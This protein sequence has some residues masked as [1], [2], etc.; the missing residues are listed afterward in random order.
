MRASS[1]RGSRSQ[2]PADLARQVQIPHRNSIGV[3][4]DEAHGDLD[5]PRPAAG[6]G[7]EQ[8]PRLGG[9]AAE[10]RVE[11]SG[12]SGRGTQRARRA[13]RRSRRAGDHRLRAAASRRP[14]AGAASPGGPGAGDD[15]AE[16]RRRCARA[17]SRKETRCCRMYSV[18]PSKTHGLRASR[19]PCQRRCERAHG[20][21]GR[22]ERSRLVGQTGQR[23]GPLERPARH[24]LPRQ[25]HASLPARG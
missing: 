9:A 5:R 1:P 3:A 10:R 8:R 4:Q 6:N 15:S 21:L 2:C 14:R 16:T 12:H 7:R 19:R 22:H 11:T 25:P 17:A 13:G 23:L 18:S 24:P 20:T